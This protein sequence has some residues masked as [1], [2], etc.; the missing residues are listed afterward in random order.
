MRVT[1]L[2][3]YPFRSGSSRPAGAAPELAVATGSGSRCSPEMMARPAP[4]MPSSVAQPGRRKRDCRNRPGQAERRSG[5]PL[6]RESTNQGR[7]GQVPRH[8]LVRSALAVLR[9][10]AGLPEAVLLAFHD[11]CVTRQEAALLQRAA[12][13][14]I[15]FEQRPGNA[16]LDGVRL[17]A[18]AA[19]S[20]GDEGVITPCGVGGFQWFER[21]HAG[22]NSPEVLLEIFAVDRDAAVA[23]AQEHAGYGSLAAAGTVILF[24]QLSSTSSGCWAACGCADPAYTFRR[25]MTLR[26]SVFLGSMPRTACS[27]M[28]SGCVFSMRPALTL[29][30]PPW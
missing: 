23:G 8:R 10:A 1:L 12:E 30:S 11:A 19:A 25:D 28:R 3:G 13:V 22:E 27:R 20:D 2:I 16:E 4:A 6:R 15:D 9:S 29:F 7:T 26:P 21:L 14:R 5:K 17:A 18:R 24:H